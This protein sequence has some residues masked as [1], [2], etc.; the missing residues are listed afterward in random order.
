MFGRE[1][2]MQDLLMLWDAIFADSIGFDLVDYIFAA[3]MLYIRELCEYT[4]KKKYQSK[5]NQGQNKGV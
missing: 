4:I 1:F 3:M 5:K 2:P